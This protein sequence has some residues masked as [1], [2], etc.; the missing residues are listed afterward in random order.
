MDNKLFQKELLSKTYQELIRQHPKVDEALSTRV[1][2]HERRC[3]RLLITEFPFFIY[4]EGLDKVRES[5]N[6]GSQS[7]SKLNQATKLYKQFLKTL[8]KDIEIPY[9]NDALAELAKKKQHKT[10][11]KELMLAEKHLLN[12]WEKQ[13]DTAYSKWEL[14]IIAESRQQLLKEISEWLKF[15]ETISEKVSA[16]GL[17]LGYFLD[18]SNGSLSMQDMSSLKKWCNY[19]AKD[20]GVKRLC[21]LLGKIERQAKESTLETIRQT[22]FISATCPD[23]DGNE[24]IVGITLAKDLERILPSELALL[25]NPASEVLFDVKFVESNL[26]CFDFVGTQSV[27]EEIQVDKQIES[28]QTEE[29]GPIIICVDTSGSMHGQPETIAKA[30]TLYLANKAHQEDRPCYLINF[31]TQIT[32]HDLSK[33]YSFKTLINFLQASFYGGTD[34]TPAI[35][36]GIKIMEQDKFKKSDMII[37][38]DFIMNTLPASVIESISKL[39]SAENKFYSLCIGEA[40]LSEARPDYFDE[41]W[42]FT[43]HNNRVIELHQFT[44]KIA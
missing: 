33:G 40:F 34:V 2:D 19:L 30:I 38:S 31:S 14:D 37:I 22:E 18:L 12:E 8:K 17:D 26:L 29:K 23:P 5:L 24:E 7:F 20:E 9:W 42:I 27:A 4:K 16:M 13:V 3:H 11:Q 41:E 1:K 15:L 28:T 43:P 6:K 10:Y 32:T 35:K 39:K 25:S 44:Q 36:H 21:D